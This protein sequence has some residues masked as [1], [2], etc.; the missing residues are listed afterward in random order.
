M[1]KDFISYRRRVV[2]YKKE[3][4]KI[5]KRAIVF[6][7]LLLLIFFHFTLEYL[8]IPDKYDR[9]I[10]YTIDILFSINFTYYLYLVYH[11]WK[12]SDISKEIENK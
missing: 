5:L 6:R 2:D 3:V 8:G 11:D 9:F 12:H 4:I 7:S 1:N 10:Y